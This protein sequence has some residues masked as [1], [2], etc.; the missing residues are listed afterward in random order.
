MSLLLPVFTLVL[1]VAGTF[2]LFLAMDQDRKA[3]EKFARTSPQPA[4]LSAYRLHVDH[5]GPR[6]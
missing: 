2:C 3:R 4:K 5:A 6:K 1:V